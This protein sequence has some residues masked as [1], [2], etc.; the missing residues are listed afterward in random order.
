MLPQKRSAASGRGTE[1]F[2]RK[3]AY[4][5]DTTLAIVGGKMSNPFMWK[6]G[7]DLLVYTAYKYGG[8]RGYLQG[9]DPRDGSKTHAGA[10]HKS[11]L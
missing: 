9:I 1:R 3:R 4:P 2:L 5:D 10:I 11:A 8:G 7:K 6:A